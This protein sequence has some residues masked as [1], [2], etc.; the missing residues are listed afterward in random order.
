MHYYNKYITSTKLIYGAG[1]KIQTYDIRFT[2]AT[3]YQL[4]Y[5]GKN[6]WWVVRESNP[7]RLD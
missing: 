2:R 1:S 4:S 5:T 3:L 6:Y 7:G